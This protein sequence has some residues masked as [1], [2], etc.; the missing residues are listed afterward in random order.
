MGQNKDTH[1][2]ELFIEE[3]ENSKSGSIETHIVD[4]CNKKLELAANYLEKGYA[5]KGKEGGAGIN[6]DMM[7][8]I[9]F[10]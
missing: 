1:I 5:K 8:D 6:A 9:L 7:R 4:L 10:D 2:Y 3:V